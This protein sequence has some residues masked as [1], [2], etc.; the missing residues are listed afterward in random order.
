MQGTLHSHRLVAVWFADIAGYSARAAKDESGAL[1]LIEILQALSRDIIHQHGGRVVKFLGDCVLAEF[2]SAQLAS[3]AATALSQRYAAR[4]VTAGAIY[5]LRIGVHVG[6]VAVASDGDLYGDAVNVAARIQET[7]EPGQVVV[8]RDVW[9]QLRR[10]GDFRFEP[11]GDRDLKGIGPTAL[12]R[13]LLEDNGIAFVPESTVHEKSIAEETIKPIR[14][15]AVL[16]FTDLSAKRD[17]EYLADGVAEEILMALARVR[18]L[19]VPA[20]ICSFAFRGASVDARVIGERLGVEAFLE[21]SIRKVENRLR[22][23]VQL[24]DTRNGYHLWSEQF[25]REVEDIF[26]IQ[27][28]IA[29]KVL[30]GIGLTITPREERRLHTSSTKNVE[31]YEFYLRGRRL[32]QK[33][34]RENIELAR[35]MFQRAIELDPSFAEAW[36][37]LATAYVH[38]FGWRGRESDLKKAREASTRSLALD[39]ESAEAHVAAGQGFSTE[40]RYTEAAAEFEK[41]TELDPGLF[42]AYYYYARSC[43]KAGDLDKA[44]QLFRRAQLVAPDDYQCAALMALVL[45]QLGHR[46]EAHDADQLALISVKR[47]LDLNPD[48]ARAY[49]LGAGVLGRLGQFE[50]AKQWNERA[51][52]LAAD[53]DAVIYNA[54]CAFAVLGEDERALDVLEQAIGA[55]LTGGDWIL[56]DPDWQ[57]LRDHP[58]FQ[59]LIKQLSRC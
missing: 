26:A 33:W 9:Q 5:N 51:L 27:D 50:Q 19:R 35:Q 34:T 14:S 55:G 10:R 59:A 57:R 18:N 24:I 29:R 2:S 46:N 8:S 56:R 25:D 4:S 52:S 58:R 22:V 47:H 1:R 48:D 31:A 41:A 49:S 53:D 3:R 13:L 42:D 40:Q 39:P 43:F 38:L 28:E 16:P 37:G 6:E 45:A 30:Q 15:V 12:Y 7:A 17:E 23:A 11:L 36:A 44:L 32:F 20:R 54:S 21:G